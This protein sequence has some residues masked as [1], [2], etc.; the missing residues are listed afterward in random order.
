M[1][2]LNTLQSRN[3][4][5]D[6]SWHSQYFPGHKTHFDVD[7]EEDGLD[8]NPVHFKQKHQVDGTGMF[9][10]LDGNPGEGQHANYLSG[11][12]PNREK[13][14]IKN[15]SGI[16]GSLVLPK[17]SKLKKTC[18]GLLQ[19]SKE[20][21]RKN[22]GLNRLKVKKESVPMRQRIFPLSFWQQ[23][24]RTPQASPVDI[25]TILPPLE[26]RQPEETI[27]G[28]LGLETTSSTTSQ[29]YVPPK[30]E[31]KVIESDKAAYFL[32]KMFS[33]INREKKYMKR[34][35]KKSLVPKSDSPDL[36]NGNDPYM[37]ESITEMLKPKL[38]L[39]DKNVVKSCE[40]APGKFQYIPLERE[41]E[42][43]LFLPGI[44]QDYNFPKLLREIVEII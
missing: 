31:Y 8:A 35:A 26:T 39:N 10:L 32:E 15:S 19:L 44:V 7:N 27:T 11:L 16:D 29:D 28:Q 37:V 5:L 34:K 30:K 21:K 38:N 22:P 36:L 18:N 25:Y 23:P 12:R 3:I 24:N 6:T 40:D 43:P 41:K 13:F 20:L 17:K 33:V 4:N 2:S 42:P 9:P 14:N 1:T